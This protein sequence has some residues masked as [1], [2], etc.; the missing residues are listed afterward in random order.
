M[1]FDLI[2]SAY[3]EGE[4]YNSKESLPLKRK[5]FPL[6]GFTAYLT[7]Y[8]HSDL[9]AH[10]SIMLFNKT[11]PLG[12]AV[13]II[14]QKI[15][16]LIPQV[17]IKGKDEVVSGHPVEALLEQPNADSTR[18]EFLYRMAAFYLITGNSYLSASG[19]VNREP[20]E[21]S[22]V[23]PQTVVDVQPD[24]VDGLASF[25]TVQTQS[26]GLVYTREEVESRFRYYWRDEAELWQIKRFNPNAGLLTGQTPISPILPEID[27]Y[28]QSSTHN[29]SLLK[30]GARPSGI[31]MISPGSGSTSEEIELLTDDQYERLRAQFDQ[32]VGSANSG[33]PFIVEA[34]GDVDW[35]DLLTTNRDMELQAGRQDV[36]M[37]IYNQFGVPLPLVLAER[38]T[39]SNMDT[40]NDQLYD[41]AVLPLADRLF[42]ELNLFLMPR[43]RNGDRFTLTYDKSNIPALESRRTREVKE[44]GTTGI[45]TINELRT[46]AGMEALD[47]GGDMIYRPASMVPIAQDQYTDDQFS[48]PQKANRKRFR[49]I[50][51]A[52]GYSEEKISEMSRVLGLK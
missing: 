32:F 31:L 52:K 23:Y 26:H 28:N 10:T 9:A 43:Y 17:T 36:R 37:A 1:R 50:M 25:F 21:V 3:E 4:S 51:M 22:N 13:D 48:E 8:G 27:W 41:N 20:S 45:Y 49:E 14:S 29:I 6:G 18:N 11:S 33:R 38:Q 42:G 39:F 12:N 44:K 2:E 35:K 16:S 5:S 15:S 46:I 7:E 24:A 34:G 19:P 40:A 47:E 30:R